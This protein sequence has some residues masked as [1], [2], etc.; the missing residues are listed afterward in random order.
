FVQPDDYLALQIK[1]T[2]EDALPAGEDGLVR[3]G[4]YV[5][6]MTDA[7]SDLGLD[8]FLIKPWFSDRDLLRLTLRP[9]AVFV[10]TPGPQ[11][12]RALA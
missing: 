11:A 10:Q 2:V 9:Q 8:P 1:G 4:R 3:A 12:G 7:L 6:L 5:A